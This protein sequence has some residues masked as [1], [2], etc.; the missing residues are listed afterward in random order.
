MKKKK[1]W[2]LLILGTLALLG[3]AA[4]DHIA[5][6][7]DIAGCRSDNLYVIMGQLG[8]YVELYNGNIPGSSEEL[9]QF[10]KERKQTGSDYSECHLARQPFLWKPKEIRTRDGRP[11]IVMCPFGSHGLFRKFSWGLIEDGDKFCFVKVRLNGEVVRDS[12]HDGGCRNVPG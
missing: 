10:V 3:L 2:I 11:V 8:E 5:Y 6:H 9:R 12:F 1:L 7:Y 4:L